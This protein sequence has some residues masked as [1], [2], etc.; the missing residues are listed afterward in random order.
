MVIECGLFF[1]KQFLFT[2]LSVPAAFPDIV[3]KCSWVGWITLTVVH[4]GLLVN[5]LS[6]IILKFWYIKCN[7]LIQF[8]PA[9]VI[10]NSKWSNAAKIL[11]NKHFVPITF[12]RLMHVSYILHFCSP[13]SF[14]FIYIEPHFS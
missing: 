3:Q 7:F 14:D 8:F 11:W 12:W 6:S 5:Y 10:C 4:L 2:V 9:Q 1:L 13:V